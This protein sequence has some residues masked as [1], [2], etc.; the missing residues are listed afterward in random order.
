M[1]CGV[2]TVTDSFSHS[3]L[4]F[5]MSHLSVVKSQYGFTEQLSNLPKETSYLD[6]PLS[7]VSEETSF[8]LCQTP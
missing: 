7:A 2:E 6:W 1:D 8:V 4:T 3:W 5:F